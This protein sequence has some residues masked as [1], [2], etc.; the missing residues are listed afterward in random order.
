MNTAKTVGEFMA[1]LRHPRKAEMALVLDLIRTADPAITEGIK[2]NAPSFAVGEHF[3]TLN[4]R[5]QDA[6]QIILHLGAKVRHDVSE[7]IPI[8]DPK[9]LL[10][11]L[12]KDRASVKFH[13]AREIENHGA[14]FQAV[15][16]EWIEYL[17]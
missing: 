8:N 17:K 10:H 11:W 1:R 5:D 15:L 7:R 16:R 13:D 6:V 12:G 14:A 4:A 2:W 9:G 3:A